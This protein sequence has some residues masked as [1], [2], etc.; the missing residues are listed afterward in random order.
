MSAIVRGKVDR[1]GEY[2]V[3]AKLFLDYI[4][5]LPSGKVEIELVEDGLEV[6]SGVQE[7]ILKG[8]PASEF[9]LLPQI[10]QDREYVIPADDL[11]RAISRVAF[12]ASASESR[13]ELTGVAC[14]FA[15]AD[16]KIVF[17]ATDS[18]RLAEAVVPVEGLS[19]DASFIVPSRAMV[20]LGRILSSYADAM[21]DVTD[22]RWRFTDNQLVA[23]FGS[24]R[25]VTRL[26]EGSFPPYKEIIPTLFKTE[27]SLVKGELQKAVRAASLFARQ[28]L[29][30]VHFSFQPDKEVCSVASADQGIGKTKTALQGK[31]EGEVAHVTLNFRYVADGLQAIA[32]ERVKIRMVDANSPVV[33]SA[34]GGE[35]A[36]QYLVMPIRQ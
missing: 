36:Y 9:P 3:P 14:Q 30:D 35:D 19:A 26:I 20:E 23:S 27:A 6:R 21:E 7:T 16:K 4:T 11:K 2:T 34:D 29:F 28:G 32:S 25:L 31:I 17:V 12:A 24:A 15:G 1:D 33:F 18:Y 22:V 5:L 8:L 13:P 10:T